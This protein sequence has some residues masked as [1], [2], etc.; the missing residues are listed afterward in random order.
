MAREITRNECSCIYRIQNIHIHTCNANVNCWLLHH[1]WLFARGLCIQGYTGAA[2]ND[3]FHVFFFNLFA[4]VLITLQQHIPSFLYPTSVPSLFVEQDEQDSKDSQDSLI[5]MNEIIYILL[6][7]RLAPALAILPCAPHCHSVAMANATVFYFSV[8]WEPTAVNFS[9]PN[10]NTRRFSTTVSIPRHAHSTCQICSFITY[11][12]IYENYAFVASS[13]CENLS[14]SVGWNRHGNIY[15]AFERSEY[16]PYILIQTIVA[17]D[18][19]IGRKIEIYLFFSFSSFF[20]L[21]WER[22]VSRTIWGAGDSLWEK[23]IL[24]FSWYAPINHDIWIQ[25]LTFCSFR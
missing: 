1:T 22:F 16:V 17:A 18:W 21:R 11:T 12:W 4:K 19:P 20:C 5:E 7:S 2:C 6:C 9:E 14:K 25:G 13:W 10:G 3:V 23:K 24:P 8:R 15:F